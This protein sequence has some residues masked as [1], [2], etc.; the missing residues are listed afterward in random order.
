MTVSKF[1][2]FYNPALFPIYD[3]EV[4]WKK[5]CNGRFRMTSGNSATVERIPNNIVGDNAEDTRGLS[6]LLHD[7]GE[8]SLAHPRVLCRYSAI[9]WPKQP[10]T[11][12]PK[13]RFEPKNTLCQGLRVHCDR[14]SKCILKPA[15][16]GGSHSQSAA[17]LQAPKGTE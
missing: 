10:G 12:L 8:V 2:H 15:R 5:V 13:R 11:D 9:G 1:L 14:R 7:L 17:E 16:S 6:A 4:M 3:Y